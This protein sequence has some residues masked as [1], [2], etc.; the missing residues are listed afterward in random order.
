MMRHRTCVIVAA[1]LMWA[2]ASVSAEA[3]AIS[4]LRTPKVTANELVVSP[5]QR[6]EAGQKAEPPLTD[7]GSGFARP[8][9]PMGVIKTAGDYEFFASD[10]GQHSRQ[11][12]QGYWVG[13]NKSGSVVT[14][15]GTLDNP[16]G[17]G[18]PQDVG[19]S[20]SPDPAVKPNYPIYGYKGGG[21]VHQVPAGMI[22][23]GNLL[24]A[25][26]AELPNGAL[27]AAWLALSCHDR[28]P[29]VQG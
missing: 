13:N 25:Y 5:K 29:L 28:A 4:Q 2:A 11:M 15:V 23:A 24:A 12:W 3:Q 9:T 16:L 21:P 18:G 6:Y 26:H 17:P 10:G 14:I 7:T 27:Y 8:D 1:C 20:P 19:I 22:G